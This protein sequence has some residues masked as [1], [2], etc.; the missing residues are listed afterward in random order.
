MKVKFSMVPL[1]ALVMMALPITQQAQAKEEAPAPTI[2]LD[3]PSLNN[4]GEI[5]VSGQ[6]PAGAQVYVEVYAA[7]KMVRANRFDSKKDPKTGK[8]PYK[9]YLTH[10]LPAFYKIF[11]PKDMEPELEAARNAGSGWKYSEVLKKI[12]ADASYNAPAKIKIDSYQ[13]TIMASILGSRGNLLDPMNEKDSKRES[14]KLVK[15]RF[16]SVN[17]LLAATVETQPDGAYTAKM[18]LRTGLAPGKYNV[19]VT[20]V[21]ERIK[22]GDKETVKKVNSEVASFDNIQ[23]FPIVY[24]NTA[25]TSINLLW[26]FLLTLGIS[27]FG[28]L[29]GA[30]GGFILNPILVSIF[31]ALPHTIVAG[32]VM[33]TVLFSQGSGIYN[34]SKIKFI[35]WK[36]GIGIGCAMMV[37][38]FIGPKLTELITLDQF[39]FA[40]GWILLVLSALMFWQT[41][42]GYLEKNK[43]EQAILKEFKKRAEECAKRGEEGTKSCPTDQK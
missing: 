35:N 43:K 42:P 24:L 9:F 30:G 33:P 32:T 36:L 15:G 38:G 10:E 6:A 22:D 3:K 41:T 12:G 34:Y 8:I 13:A 25:G 31:P 5:T 11:V 37:G 26:P 17:N 18:K 23:S 19:I 7:D 1:L 27:I 40:F 2:T 28:V 21:T 20:A 14:M 4:G 29:M 39:K 16:R